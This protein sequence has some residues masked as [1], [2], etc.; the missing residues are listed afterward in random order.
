MSE[1]ALRISNAEETLWQWDTNQTVTVT[2]NIAQVH[3]ALKG[4]ESAY[5]VPVA[6][7]TAGI[8][9]SLLQKSGYLLAYAYT[10]NHTL[11][12][13][14]WQIHARPVP[15]T[16]PYQPDIDDP[17]TIQEA[18]DT[19]NSNIDRIDSNV[20]QATN[21]RNIYRG[22]N[23]GTAITAAQKTAI[24]SGTFDDLFVGDYW[25]LNGTVYRIADMDYWLNC[26]D[27]AFT[28]HHLVMVP[29]GNMYNAPMND[30]N[31]TDG[32][33]VGS[34]MY[35]E[36]LDNAK[37]TIQAAFGNMLQTHRENLTNAVTEGYPSGH[38]WYDST[39]D[40]MNEI[41]IYGCYIHMPTGENLGVSVR[42]TI[43]KQQL[44]LFQLNPRMVNIKLNFWLRDVVS[45]ARFSAAYN[46]GEATIIN[47]SNSFGVRP[48][49]AIG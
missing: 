10:P 12:E 23:L 30:T 34:K 24:S 16:Y 39:L 37:A 3:F 22:K 13:E 17:G 47:A 21:H 5:V 28:K 44:A 32:G 4:N 48:V 31:T 1:Y 25:T 42:N 43:D 41:M 45:S 33:Y 9:N 49:F 29:D 6:N 35:T 2:G 26:G 7:G 20:F 8:P 14:E 36:G 11:L 40:L 18:L 46:N 27:T 38:A 19:I 15:E